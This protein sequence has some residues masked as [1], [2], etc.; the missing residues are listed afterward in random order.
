MKK[1]LLP[2]VRAVLP[3]KKEPEICDILIDIESSLIEKIG[4]NLTKEKE[5]VFLKE[6]EG[7]TVFPGFIDPHVHFRTPGKTDA[8]DWLHASKAALSAG[9]TTVLDMPNN[10]PPV[11]DMAS[12]ENKKKIISDKSLV[13]FGLFAALTPSNSDELKKIETI[14][15]IKVYMASTTGNI[16]IEDIS[17]IDAKEGGLLFAFHAEDEPTIRENEKRFEGEFTPLAHTEIRSEEAAVKAVKKVIDLQKKTGGNFHVCHVSVADELDLLKNTPI[18]HEVCAHH[19]F[20]DTSHYETGGFLW[21]CNPP[22]RKPQTREKLLDSLYQEDIEMIAT[23]HAPHLLSEKVKK[24]GMPP[25]GVPSIEAGTHLVLNE[26]F[27]GK[28]NYDYAA[29]ILSSNAAKR[30]NIRNRGQIREGFFADIAVI[31]EKKWIFSKND[32]FSKCGWNPFEGLKLRAKVTASFVNGTLYRREN[33]SKIQKR[34][35]FANIFEV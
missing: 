28:I 8:E 26:I 22:L 1:I 10:N 34:D 18:S 12:Y 24:E 15:G 4:K 27:S 30:F 11:I 16:L 23:D 20:A 29:K 31:E 13:N 21:K 9:V 17:K 33:L 32:V 14:K 7:L 5:C 25:S 6:F 19:L 35:S 3:D 2:S